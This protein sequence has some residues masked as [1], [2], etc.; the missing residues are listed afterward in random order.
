[1]AVKAIN[2]TAGLNRLV[3]TLLVFSAFPWMSELDPPALLIIQHTAAVKKVIN[4][5]K[6]LC[7]KM[8]VQKVLNYW[9]GPLITVIYDLLINSKV[10]I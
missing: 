7:A 2:N 10:L 4:E 8:Q 9:N 3:L 1:M 6:E 5:I